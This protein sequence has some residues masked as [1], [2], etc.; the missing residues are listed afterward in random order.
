MYARWLWV[1]YL[2]RNACERF[3]LPEIVC[4]PSDL[5]VLPS[6]SSCRGCAVAVETA[7]MCRSSR[8]RSHRCRE[9]ERAETFSKDDFSQIWLKIV[10]TY[11]VSI[12]MT[13]FHDKHDRKALIFNFVQISWCYLFIHVYPYSEKELNTIEFFFT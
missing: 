6:V 2:P 11:N 7:E 3:Y 1:R 9:T 10:N 13:A 5:T 8:Y 12:E 4:S